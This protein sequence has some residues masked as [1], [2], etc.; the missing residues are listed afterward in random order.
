MNISKISFNIQKY[1]NFKKPKKQ[2][3]VKEANSNKNY[4]IIRK[5]LTDGPLPH[6]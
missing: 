3:L 6:I 4:Q 2:E 5:G 1:K